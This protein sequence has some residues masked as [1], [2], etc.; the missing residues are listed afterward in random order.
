MGREDEAVLFAAIVATSD[1][2]AAT[3]SRTAK[4]DALAALLTDLAPD[5]IAPAVGMLVGAPRQG[6]IGVG[7]ATLRDLSRPPAAY[8]TLTIT[9]VDRLLTEVAATSGAGS[10]ARR[11]EL[12]GAT[13]AA[14]TERE[15]DFVS[16]LLIG[17]L[18]H[19]AQEGALVDAIA[20]A[21]SL[22]VTA[23]RRAFM[24]A[25][26]LGVTATAA[27]TGGRTA[28]DAIG[29]SVRTPVRPMLASTAETVGQAVGEAD[30]AAVA[31]E[32][33]LDGAR[34]QVHRDDDEVAV[35]TRNL[36]DV[37]A[38]LP[39]VV[40]IVRALPARQLVLDGE[41]LGMVEQ[42]DGTD[43][44]PRAFQDTMSRF[45]RDQA[46]RGAD[47]ADGDRR[48]D[49]LQPWFF[50]VLH[51]D[52]DDLI[53]EPYSVRAAILAESVGALRIPGI[54]TADPLEAQRFLD[55][56]IAAGHEGVLVKDLDSAYAAG[57]RGKAWR[58][59]KPVH[60]VDLVVLAAEWGHGRR[61]GWL[62]NLHLGAR[63]PADPSRFI[64]VGKTFKGL[65]DALLTWQTEALL[66]REIGREDHVVHVAPE[67][68]VEVGLDGVQASVRYPGGV[69]L[70]FARVRRYRPDKAPA[71]ADT[72]E[73][74]QAL[75]PRAHQSPART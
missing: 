47:G 72:I 34:I 32:W 59:V 65:T 29:L 5:E 36:N 23:V 58:K 3:S 12:L 49:G 7:W 53:D 69:A 4:R 33:K 11:A 56:T 48:G 19:G 35:F 20:T 39:E 42:G 54:V 27:L 25:G 30:G 38:R 67:L 64:M 16:R 37:T 9:A 75:L 68:V 15:Q 24:L 74:L 61:R 22:P 1:A 18:R 50:D 51:R 71:E 6:R 44:M 55:A 13:F 62:S 21:A 45:G 46:L 70:R 57:R 63:D 73:A 17:E 14:A 31:V 2:V 10:V 28:L 52:G 41:V 40:A 26:D 43:V 60:V 66:A 8:P